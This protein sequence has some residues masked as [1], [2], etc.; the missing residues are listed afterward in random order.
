MANG[1]P[2]DHPLTDLFLHRLEVYGQEADDLIREIASLSSQRE[3]DAWWDREV[4]WSNDRDLVCRKAR[5]QRQILL[6]R[7]QEAAGKNTDP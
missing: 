3:F 4:G 6:Q 1:K 2:G 7:A 5:A